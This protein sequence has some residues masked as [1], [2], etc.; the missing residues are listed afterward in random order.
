M[1]CELKR[2]GDILEDIYADRENL[3]N[4]RTMVEEMGVS[5]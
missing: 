5:L 1:N 3:S 2:K 4:I